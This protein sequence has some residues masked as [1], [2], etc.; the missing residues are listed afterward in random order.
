MEQ[1]IINLFQDMSILTITLL[2][3]GMLLC[4]AEIFV[5]KVGLTGIL[6]IVLLVMGVSSYYIDG[7]RVKYIIGLLGIMALVLA[8]FIM[9]ELILEGKG[10]IKNPDRSKFRTY[11][12]PNENLQSLVG[13]KG[14]AVTNIDL[15]G[16]IEINGKLY[17]AISNSG[18][19]K[20]SIVEVIGVKNNALV[21]R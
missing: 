15:G 21:V 7:F 19:A 6:G 2:S 10:V 13:R 11:N 14:K 4:I 8:L 9:I 17:Y 3:A 18:I 5:P 12:N 20:G 16:T 1:Y